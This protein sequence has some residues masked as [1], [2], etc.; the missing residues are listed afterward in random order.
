MNTRHRSQG[1]QQPK[2]TIAE[3]T[4]AP[5]RE[6]AMLAATELPPPKSAQHMLES[7][8]ESIER[9]FTAAKLGTV[10]VNRK[11]IDI[12]RTNVSSGLDL[13]MGLAT[14]KTP[15]EAARLQMAF[16]DRHLKTFAAQ[17]EELRALQAELMATANEPLREHLRRS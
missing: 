17:A 1:R 9:S 7:A 11:L 15:M 16:F 13:A 6:E 14:A 8:F 12:A 2:R 4:G 5:R 3:A 10:A